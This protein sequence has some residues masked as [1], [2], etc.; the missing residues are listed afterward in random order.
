[1]EKLY[2]SKE[3]KQAAA[4]CKKNFSCLTG[5]RK[6]LCPILSCFDCDVHFILGLNES[7]C[8]FQSKINERVY[9]ECPIRIELYEKHKI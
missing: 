8:A 9:C 4:K 7:P 6:D 3:L 5:E 2:I 1:M